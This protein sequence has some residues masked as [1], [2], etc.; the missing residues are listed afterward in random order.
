[1]SGNYGSKLSLNIILHI[2]IL[3][4]I[5]TALYILYISKVISNFLNNELAG[6]VKTEFQNNLYVSKDEWRQICQSQLLTTYNYNSE[7]K[8]YN[9]PPDPEEYY[10]GFTNIN[11]ELQLTPPRRSNM[12]LTE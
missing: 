1:M 9:L 10:N 5:L 7:Y 8:K 12:R 3:F 11:N 2:T 4:T 6:I